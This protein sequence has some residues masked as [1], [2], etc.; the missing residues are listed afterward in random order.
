MELKTFGPYIFDYTRNGRCVLLGGKKGHI[1]G[2]EWKKGVLNTEI[3]VN[4]NIMDVKCVKNK[5]K[6][7]ILLINRWLH[8]E[9]LFVAAQKKYVYMYDNKGIEVHCLKR[10]I[11]VLYMEFLPYHYLLATIVYKE[12][13]E[14]EE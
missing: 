2:F 10:H 14:E 9:K 12:K 13:N 11:E 3:N 1:G 4:E 6:K 8:N 7:G 5:Y